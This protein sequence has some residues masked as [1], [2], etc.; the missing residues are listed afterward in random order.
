MKRLSLHHESCT[1]CSLCELICALSHFK[2][3]HPK[4]S[5]IH[6]ERKF[7]SPGSFEIRVCNQCG[8][9]KEV[10]PAEA[11]SEKDGVYA[12]DPLKCN[13]CQLCIDECPYG[14]LYQHRDLSIPIKCDQCGECV[15]VCTPEAIR[16]SE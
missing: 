2:E 15:E 3:N 5:A 6:I 1:G 4:K 9:C 12:I 13:F 11:I 7:P 14:A 8:R 16:W 10:C